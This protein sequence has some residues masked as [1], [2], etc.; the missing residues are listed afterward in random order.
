MDVRTHKRF[1]EYLERVEYVAPSIHR[2][3]ARDEW[4]VLD[5]ELMSLTSAS[6]L[7]DEAQGR[8]RVLKKALLRD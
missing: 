1:L 3:L 7:D 8:I 5:A 4:A 2:R 6:H